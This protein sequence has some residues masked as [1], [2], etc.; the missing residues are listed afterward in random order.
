MRPLAALT[1]APPEGDAETAMQSSGAF[2]ELVP[3]PRPRPVHKPRPRQERNIRNIPDN[4]LPILLAGSIEVQPLR[5]LH[6]AQT[7]A[8]SGSYQ[9]FAF[10]K[11]SKIFLLTHF[12]F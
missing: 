3:S 7:Q 6:L 8:F 2:R 11:V 5:H 4:V 1:A 9:K 12:D 10:F